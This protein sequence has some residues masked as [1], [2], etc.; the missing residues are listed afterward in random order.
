MTEFVKL[1]KPTCG[2]LFD[3]IYSSKFFEQV[4]RKVDDN[5]RH[6]CYVAEVYKR[7]SD[8]TFWRVTY[9]RSTDGETNGLR[10]GDATICRVVPKTV[11]VTRY[12]T[13][14]NEVVS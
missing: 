12:E 11:S 14:E 9:C 13:I 3:A 8:E 7:L 6:G 2:E 10:D 5:R 1:E 4:D